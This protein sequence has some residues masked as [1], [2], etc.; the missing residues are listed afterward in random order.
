VDGL[1]TLA[2]LSDMKGFTREY[3]GLRGTLAALLKTIK[4]AKV[5]DLKTYF[6][7]KS[8]VMKH[9][10]TKLPYE[11][12]GLFRAE[13]ISYLSA[14]FSDTKND[15]NEFIMKIENPT[16]E[17]IMEFQKEYAPI[18]TRIEQA[19]QSI[20]LLAVNRSKKTLPSW[21]EEEHTKV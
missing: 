18:K 12:G 8:E 1:A 2:R 6:L 14:G 15:L 13:E 21:K 20:R 17:F 4:P 19:E 7:P 10:K 3:W 9:I 11:N 16:E 5:S